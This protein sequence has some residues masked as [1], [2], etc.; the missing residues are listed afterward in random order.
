MTAPGFTD[1]VGPRGWTNFIQEYYGIAPL[2]VTRTSEGYYNH[3]FSLSDFWRCLEGGGLRSADVVVIGHNSDVVLNALDKRPSQ[4]DVTRLLSKGATIS[5]RGLE[6]HSPSLQRLCAAVEWLFWCP[7]QINAYLSGDGAAGLP[8]HHDTHDVFILQLEG[9]KT[10]RLY[11][12]LIALPLPGQQVIWDKQFPPAPNAELKLEPGDL[13]YLPR[14]LPHDAT[15]VGGYSLHVTLGIQARTWTEVFIEAISEVALRSPA[16][17][18]A[19][20]PQ[21]DLARDPSTVA[22]AFEKLLESF[23]LLAR[24]QLAMANLSRDFI[25]TRQF[26]L[27]HRKPASPS[28]GPRTTIKA[29]ESL[30]YRLTCQHGQAIVECQTMRLEAPDCALD[31]LKSALTSNGCAVEVLAGPISLAS[32]IAI[33]TRLVQVGLV[34]VCE[35]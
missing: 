25:Q 1:F 20:P 24:P 22:S 34:I 29:Q 12:P 5:L 3:Y 23:R 15:A 18:E 27:L 32:K 13:L 10:W 19:L 4:S 31:T 17:R 8:I 9:R 2:H 28:I 6:S 16:F 26:P 7:V 33:V 35:A 21:Y 11:E 30:I 14:G